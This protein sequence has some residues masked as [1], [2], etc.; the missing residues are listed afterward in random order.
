MVGSSLHLLLG[1]G[2]FAT[3]LVFVGAF[4][5]ALRECA[6]TR[7]LAC[8]P[9]IPRAAIHGGERRWTIGATRQRALRGVKLVQ[10]GFIAVGIT[11][12]FVMTMCMC[13]IVALMV[14]G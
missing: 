1:F 2:V 11:A 4:R 6:E 3:L 13:G 10:A 14:L 9:D 12:V 5:F 8:Q 7:E